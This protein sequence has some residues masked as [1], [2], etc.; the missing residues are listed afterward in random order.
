LWFAS[1]PAEPVVVPGD[2]TVAYAQWGGQGWAVGRRVVR[3]INV[4]AAGAVVDHDDPASRVGAAL[5]SLASPLGSILRIPLPRR[6]L[7]PEVP[8]AQLG[9][10][11][12]PSVLRLDSD[13]L[14]ASQ[15]AFGGYHAAVT[16][17]AGCWVGALAPASADLSLAWTDAYRRPEGE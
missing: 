15:W 13:W 14:Y 8:A 5:Y 17:A 7:T 16:L 12:V 11:G 6:L 2:I 9:A 1:A 3:E 4:T 10:A